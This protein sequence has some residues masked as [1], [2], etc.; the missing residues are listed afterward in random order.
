MTNIIRKE[1][2]SDRVLFVDG[3]NG[4]GKTLFSSIFASLSRLEVMSY[5]YELEM[6]CACFFVEKI[7]NDAALALT[8]MLTDLKLYNLMM[9]RET[10]FRP[11]D[12]S[13]VFKHQDVTK[14]FQRLFQPGDEAVPKRIL[15]ERPILNLATHNLLG[16]SEPIFQSLGD[17]C[18]FVEVVR[19][20][21]YMIRQQRLNM[22][23][24][25]ENVRN[26]SVNIEYRG[27][28]LPYYTHGWE[29][30]FVNSTTA[31]EKSVRSI[32]HLTKRT[33]LAKKMLKEKYNAK[34]IT[35]PFEH[36]VLN[37]DPW[38]KKVCNLLQTEPTENTSTVMFQQNIPRKKVSDGI[39]LAIYQRC[40]WEPPKENISEK[41]ELL[42]RRK[43]F[44]KELSK[45]HASL[46]DQI[47]MRY[48]STY[49]ELYE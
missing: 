34:I 37:P 20:P 41:G 27:R 46:L 32:Y 12:L 16:I 45:E 6:I 8:R 17:R 22:Q 47:C 14:Y 1:H 5:I 19:H 25:L 29:E 44:S 48:E 49:W 15:D 21:L 18:V 28:S 26:F 43:E 39:A 2:L 3:Q 11:T 7:S 9:G 42:I 30:D 36:F 40:G 13:S 38:L 31:T 24:L 4:C 10:N 23:N 33:E 35:I